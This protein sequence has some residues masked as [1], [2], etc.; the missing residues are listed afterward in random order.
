MFYFSSILDRAAKNEEGIHIGKVSDFLISRGE[1][2][3]RIDYI[4]L[5][6]KRKRERIPWEKVKHVDAE[7][8]I[9]LGKKQKFPEVDENTQEYVFL[10]RDILDMQIVDINGHRVVRVNDIQLNNVGKD[11]RVAGVDVGTPG[12]LRRMGF[13]EISDHV[14]KFLKLKTPTNIIPWD[15]VQTLGTDPSSPIRLATT[16]RKLTRLH[17]ADLADILEDLP[18]KER[19]TLFATL[20]NETAAETLEEM[21]EDV[22]IALFKSLP[23]EKAA[24][25][26]EEM[27]PDEAADLLQDIPDE[28]AIT[29]LGLMDAEDAK[30]VQE[31]LLYEE[32][33]AGGL[34]SNDFIAASPLKTCQE[35]IEYIRELSPDYEEVYYIH[36]ID[37]KGKLLGIIPL[38]K[39]IVSSPDKSLGE[40]MTTHLVTV[41]TNAGIKEITELIAKYDFLSIPVVDDKFIMKGI[42][43]VDDVMEQILPH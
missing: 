42:I 29:L 41:P 37:E 25:I 24:D 9:I 13:L 23:D 14:S 39:I 8:V 43:T 33:T 31:L 19:K 20:D 11:L 26:L 30:D 17:P 34:M 1:K 28:R 16:Q 15:M 35:T 7:G 12:L 2:F 32:D 40:I 3:P 36:I 27:A 21:E 6:A 38:I 22:Q 5:K 4:I 18:G 10:K